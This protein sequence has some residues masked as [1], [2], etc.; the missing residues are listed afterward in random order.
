M[1]NDEAQGAMWILA[2][3]AAEKDIC[4]VCFEGPEDGERC[5]RFLLLEMI[6]NIAKNNNIPLQVKKSNYFHADKKR[7][8]S[9][10]V[11]YV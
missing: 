5:H 9:Q 3:R 2:Q 10:T 11:V 1:S 8:R 7:N 6:A 4:L